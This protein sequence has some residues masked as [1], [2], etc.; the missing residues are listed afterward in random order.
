MDPKLPLEL[1]DH[2]F[3]F[4][5]FNRPTLSNCSLTRP[6]PRQWDIPNLPELLRFFHETPSIA[7]HIRI[8]DIEGGCDQIFAYWAQFGP[9]VFVDVVDALPNLE[10]VVI[11]VASIREQVEDKDIDNVVGYPEPRVPGRHLRSLMIGQATIEG[12]NPCL[13]LY[14]LLHSISSVKFLKIAGLSSS[15]DDTSVITIRNFAKKLYSSTNWHLDVEKLEWEYECDSG[16]FL[17]EMCRKSSPCKLRHLD[18]KYYDD[19]ESDNRTAVAQEFLNDVGGG[20]ESLSIAL[21]GIQRS[22]LD[23]SPCTSLRSLNFTH[24]IFLR[25]E[26]SFPTCFRSTLDSLSTVPRIPLKLT[27]KLGYF[28]IYEISQYISSLSSLDWERF[29]RILNWHPCRMKK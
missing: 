2:I 26:Q 14:H 27:I 6:R 23:I 11:D 8:L 18:F 28:Y 13:T 25:V 17:V 15:A 7:K 20:L 19:P 5:Y 9:E 29:M 4:L 24:D 21:T 10:E 3:T 1:I 16:L 12:D 22:A